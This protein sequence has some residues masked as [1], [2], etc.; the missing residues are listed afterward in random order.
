M[1]GMDTDQFSV[2]G[3]S[4]SGTADGSGGTNSLTA[5][6]TSNLFIIDSANGGTIGSVNRFA[7]IESLTGN[8]STDYFWL[9][10]GTLSGNVDGV[11]GTNWLLGDNI[12]SEYTIDGPNAG[13][14]TGITNGFA[15]ISNIYAGTDPDTITVTET[16]TLSGSVNSSDGDDTFEITPALG[17]LLTVDGGNGLDA[18]NIDAGAGTPSISATAVTVVPGG[19]TVNYSDIETI[20]ATCNACIPPLPALVANP[21][22]EPAQQ[23]TGDSNHDGVFDSSDLVTVFL[24]GEYENDIAH[25][26]TFEE[27]DWN[28]DMDFDSADLVAAFQR[29]AYRTPVDAQGDGIAAAVDFFFADEDEKEKKKPHVFLP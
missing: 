6:N 29:G 16:G 20:A 7:N 26:S 5:D 22:T 18:M 9:S 28:G 19:A 11:S 25:D 24:S 10:G 13:Q 12:P 8:A 17:I 4:L 3:G 21:T 27:G 14:A 15:N 2:N 1:G 23:V